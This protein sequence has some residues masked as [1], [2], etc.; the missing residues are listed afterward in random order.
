M[1]YL[2]FRSETI[3]LAHDAREV[4]SRLIK[5]I[6]PLESNGEQIPPQEKTSSYLFNGILKE[7]R[8]T[9]SKIIKQPENF[10]PL[11]SGRIE[12]TSAGCIIFLKYRMFFSTNLFLG[13]WSVVTFLMTLLFV[14]GYSN[15]LY[16]TV[17]F[18]FGIANYSIAI[19]NFNA[20]IKQSKRLLHKVLD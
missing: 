4:N 12:P 8:F 19:A 16:A 3:V 1:E 11:I 14:I 9:I 7:D 6:K 2:P 20:Q 5:V 10:L 18:G 17:C 13:F 15:Y